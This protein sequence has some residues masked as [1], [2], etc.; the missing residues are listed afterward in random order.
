MPAFVIP[1]NCDGCGECIKVCPQSILHM[2]PKIRKAFNIETDMCWECLPCMKACPQTAIEVRGYADFAPL[3]GRVTCKRDTKA[4]IITW[5]IK[6]RNGRE[7]QFK[8]PIRTTPWGSIR[9]PHEY[10]PPS[11]EELK[12][13]ILC[14][15]P[16][17]FGLRE[18][19]RP[20]RPLAR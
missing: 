1:Y 16:G 11:P 2:D 4:N 8:Y 20:G 13:Q 6:F 9:S 12:S 14:G 3:G 15:E 5:F 10:P 19:P 17:I 18:L 7:L